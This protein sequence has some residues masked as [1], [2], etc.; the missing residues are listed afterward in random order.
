MTAMP[1]TD[2]DDGAAAPA[3]GDSPAPAP[4]PAP[5]APG[6]CCGCRP[7]ARGGCPTP[8]ARR[9]ANGWEG[10]RTALVESSLTGSSCSGACSSSSTEF[11]QGT[12]FWRRCQEAPCRQSCEGEI[13]YVCSFHSILCLLCILFSLFTLFILCSLWVLFSFGSLWFYTVL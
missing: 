2:G 1:P 12:R 13:R 4:A 10:L 7:T 5:A 6:Q 11:Q 9:N 3:A 8:T